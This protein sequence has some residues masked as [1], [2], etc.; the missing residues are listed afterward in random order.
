MNKIGWCD[1]T[2]NPVKGYCPVACPYCYAR[3]MYNRFKWD[4]A[5]RLDMAAFDS[6]PR[7]PSKIFVGS[8]IELYGEWVPDEW[9]EKILRVVQCNPRHTFQFLTK[10]PKNLAR[11]NPWPDNAWVG[12]TATNTYQFLEAIYGLTMVEAKIRFISFEPLHEYIPVAGVINFLGWVIIGAETGNRK[13][14][15][16]LEKGH[17][18]AREIIKAADSVG[19][20]VF[21][22]DNLQWP[23]VRREWPG[24]NTAK[25]VE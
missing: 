25:E 12:A 8:T 14:K 11:W 9:I 2:R 4:K 6:M 7:E 22:K 15:P 1:I 20:P 16:P 3:R 24:A 18:W 5:I 19:V 13:G 21:L 17:E 23:E 10:F